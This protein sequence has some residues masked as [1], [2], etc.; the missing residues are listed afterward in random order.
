MQEETNSKYKPN[1]PVIKD[2]IKNDDW[3]LRSLYFAVLYQWKWILL[4]VFV[5]V[6]AALLFNRYAINL[7]KVEATVLIN[8]PTPSLGL[9]LM[10]SIGAAPLKSNIDNEVGVLKS[11]ALAEETLQKMNINVAFFQE[12]FFIRDQLYPNVPLIVNVDWTEPQLV[13]GMFRLT[14]LDT[15]SYLLEIEDGEFSLYNPSDPYFKINIKETPSI[16]EK[17]F[18]GQDFSINHLHLNIE[19]IYGK[20]GETFLFQI[21]DTP[22]LALEFKALLEVSQI[23]KQAS[24][25]SVSLS[26]PNRKLGQD[27]LNQL[28]QEYLNRELLEKN[29]AA[30]NTVFFINRQLSGITDSLSFFEGKLQD[31][32]TENRIFNLSQEGTVVFERLNEIEVE[33]GKGRIR[34]NYFK[35]LLAYINSNNLNAIM[36]PSVIGEQDP[37][38]NSLIL[39]ILDLQAE[40]V[41]LSANFTEKAPLVQENRRKIEHTR[42]LLLENINSAIN[43]QQELLSAL[44]EQIATVEREINTLPQ[45]ER[46]LLGIQRQ[47]SINENIYIYLL[48]KRAEAEISKASNFPKNSVLDAARAQPLPISPRK[49][50][51]ILFGFLIGFVLPLLVLFIKHFLSTKIE[52]EKEL[53]KLLK[54]P[55]LGNIGRYS[56]V[57]AKAVIDNP[58]S[59]VSE[60][61]RS[62]RADMS[63]IH[64]L[65]EKITILF[66]SAISGEGKTFCAINMA[67]IFA[68]TGKKT[69]LIGLDLRKPKIGSSFGLSNDIGV[70]SYLCSDTE[71]HQLVKSSGLPN[72]DILLAGPIPPNP[73][74]LLLQDRFSQLMDEVKANYEVVI[75]DCPP[76]GLVSE[77]KD[78]FKFADVSIYVIRQDHSPKAAANMLNDIAEKGV[79]KKI[80][81]ILNDIHNY[82][83]KGYGYGYWADQHYYESDQKSWWKL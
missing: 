23:N 49:S 12:G 64:P 42:S 36:A 9:D 15:K 59:A 67:S 13:D 60:S 61:F 8:D 48:Q 35:T 28:I 4:S 46:N 21:R 83:G 82:R 11:L 66:T 53:L 63:Y 44:N 72:L 58:R 14:I 30:E 6:L 18:F 50:L 74:E 78:L 37:M 68:I 22:S 62:L 3:E 39:M 2:L 77:T 17:G 25:L 20:Q 69:L 1:M 32:R 27:Y 41:R 79:A 16:A 34:L 31:Y 54:V 57:G 33:R 81:A 10:E 51:N 29:R 80:Y 24:I 76:V 47:F 70:T 71:W 52:D 7:Y 5:G 75:M 55:L 65:H 19:N 38:L 43:N 45:T 56:G 73:A 26:T 40:Q